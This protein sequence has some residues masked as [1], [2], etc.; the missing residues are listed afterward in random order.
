M[1]SS[2]LS[3]EFI[4][5][6]DMAK[7][8]AVPT[9]KFSD[10]N[11][12][13]TDVN[14]NGVLDQADKVQVGQSKAVSVT[15]AYASENPQLARFKQS[16]LGT[17]TSGADLNGLKFATAQ[18][19]LTTRAKAKDLQEEI[20]A[21]PVQDVLE[22]YKGAKSS[23]F[24]A[25]LLA[26]QLFEKRAGVK[27]AVNEQKGE[28]AAKST[29]KFLPGLMYESAAK[30]IKA[31]GD[32]KAAKEL[33]M[34]SSEMKEV[35]QG[36]AQKH[37]ASIDNRKEFRAA[38]KDLKSVDASRDIK[39]HFK[40]DYRQ[41]EK[42]PVIEQA[43]PTPQDP[44]QIDFVGVAAGI[45]RKQAWDHSEKAAK[46]CSDI[47]GKYIPNNQSALSKKAAQSTLAEYVAARK[48]F[49]AVKQRVE[50]LIKEV[51]KLPKNERQKYKNELQDLKNEF[52]WYKQDVDAAYQSARVSAMDHNFFFPA[53]KLPIPEH[54]H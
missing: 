6:K 9:Y 44:D 54:T 23:Y 21:S 18:N 35:I 53:N 13:F 52:A 41:L 38:L 49:A 51:E 40:K 43:L 48:D 7:T 5:E 4:K 47:K 8:N 14:D 34:G 22:I 15:K 29:L 30:R 45:P 12:T 32:V 26:D 46:A 1:A 16:I 3:P 50:D 33:G 25:T 2:L 39:K 17:G 19:F 10:F 11:L 42:S 36:R 24:E 20:G 37:L 31:G 27:G 28:E